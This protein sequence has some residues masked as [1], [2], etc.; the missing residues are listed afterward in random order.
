MIEEG[1][2]N[3]DTISDDDEHDYVARIVFLKKSSVKMS[4]LTQNG[5][6]LSN[7]IF[8]PQ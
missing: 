2:L 8:S 3:I 1:L 7:L 4:N 6:K 5:V